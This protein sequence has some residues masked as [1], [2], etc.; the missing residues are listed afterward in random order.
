MCYLFFLCSSKKIC[1][2]FGVSHLTNTSAMVY[3]YIRMGEY[4]YYIY[5]YSFGSRFAAPFYYL[6][7]AGAAP[8]AN[9]CSGAGACEYYFRG[10]APF[11]GSKI[12]GAAPPPKNRGRPKNMPRKIRQFPWR[13]SAKIF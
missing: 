6:K 4:Y 7:E 5:I 11:G 10:S 2:N 1:Q 9:I 8:L 13:N 12:R 3:N